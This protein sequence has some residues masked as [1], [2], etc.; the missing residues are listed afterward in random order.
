MNSIQRLIQDQSEKQQRIDA[1]LQT[2]TDFRVH[3]DLDKFKGHDSDGAR[4]D[5]IAVQDVRD[6]L[7]QLEAAINGT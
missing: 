4:K 6:R 1:A 5:W 3:L 7:T 2:I